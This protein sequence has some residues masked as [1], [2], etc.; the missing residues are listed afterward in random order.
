[1]ILTDDQINSF[2]IR[3]AKNNAINEFDEVN[4]M[5]NGWDLTINYYHLDNVEIELLNLID[6]PVKIPKVFRKEVIKILTKKLSS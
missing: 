2:L 6:E 4:M 3:L 5:E 1:M